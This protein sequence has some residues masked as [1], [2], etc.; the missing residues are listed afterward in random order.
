MLSLEQCKSVHWLDSKN[1]NVA[2]VQILYISKNA[3]QRKTFFLLLCFIFYFSFIIY[4]LFFHNFL[5]NENSNNSK[6][7]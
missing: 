3:A 6:I 2:S 5:H 4:Y 7:M 1:A